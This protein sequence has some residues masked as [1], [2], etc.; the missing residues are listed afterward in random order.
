MWPILLIYCSNGNGQKVT[1]I[2]YREIKL[3]AHDEIALVYGK[4]P[5][6]I[7]SG[8]DFPQGV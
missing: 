1:G 8:Y 3:H 6:I 4:P 5:D 7:P 2:N